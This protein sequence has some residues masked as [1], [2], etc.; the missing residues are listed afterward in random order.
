VREVAHQAV[1]VV[2]LAL[3]TLLTLCLGE[4]AA[5]VILAQEKQQGRRRAWAARDSLFRLGRDR[6]WQRLWQGETGPI[7][8]ELRH[9]DAPN[10]SMECWQAAR[11]EVAPVQMTG[12]VGMRERLRL[13]AA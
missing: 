13:L 2:V 8:W 1:L 5:Q 4:Q 9:A 6:L 3:T 7:N 10:W 12:R 11:S